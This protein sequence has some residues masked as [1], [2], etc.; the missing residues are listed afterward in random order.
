MTA[1]PHPGFPIL[2]SSM[3]PYHLSIMVV[4]EHLQDQPTTTAAGIIS[5]PRLTSKAHKEKMETVS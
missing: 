1:H 4:L 2:E 5:L 3:R